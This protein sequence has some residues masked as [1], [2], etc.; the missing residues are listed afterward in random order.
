MQI[1]VTQSFYKLL[2]LLTMT[3]TK[4]GFFN[5]KYQQ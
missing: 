3:K 4:F 2:M 1:V 5:A